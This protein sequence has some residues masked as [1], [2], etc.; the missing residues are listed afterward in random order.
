[1]ATWTLP[2]KPKAFIIAPATAHTLGRL[3]HGLADDVL[4]CQALA[5]EGQLVLAPAMNPAM[6]RNPA[7]QAN[8]RV[9]IDRGHVPVAPVRGQAA[10]GDQGQGKLAPVER[11]YL[12]G[13]RALARQDMAGKKVLV[14]LG[15]TYEHFDPV[16]FVGNPSSG[17]MGASLALA[18]WLRGAEVHAVSGPVDLYL[19]EDIACVATTSAQEM[20]AACKQ[21]WPG[22]DFGL[23]SAAVSD[24]APRDRNDSKLKKSD[25]GD[26][27]RIDM[28]RT[29][30]ILSDL[31]SAKSPNQRVLGFAR[32]RAIW[33]K[34]PA[35]SSN[36]RM[37]TLLRP[38]P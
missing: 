15:P 20:H 21:L 14:T 33:P 18:A 2:T 38:M 12:H 16:R 22:M 9:L 7:V 36:A 31:A 17:R 11:I 5:Y 24:F 23:F 13:L 1:M 37:P 28:V 19:P 4:S 30:D 8:W 32:R 35:T 25:A 34:P 29:P 26:E 3:A 27:V 10:C 6:W